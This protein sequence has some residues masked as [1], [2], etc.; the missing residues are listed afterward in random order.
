M[1]QQRIEESRQWLTAHDVAPK[2]VRI[3]SKLRPV[4]D[5]WDLDV[6]VKTTEW[7]SKTETI[8]IVDDGNPPP[9]WLLEAPGEP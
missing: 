4:G 6:I 8:H 5:G 9:P 7:G 1:N 2:R 3:N